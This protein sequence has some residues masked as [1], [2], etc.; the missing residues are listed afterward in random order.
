MDTIACT[1]ILSFSGAAY[2]QE[3]KSL[4]LFC[5][6][7]CVRDINSSLV[8]FP[9]ASTVVLAICSPKLGRGL[10]ILTSLAACEHSLLPFLF[11]CTQKSSAGFISQ[12]PP[13]HLLQ[14]K[15]QQ[16]CQHIPA[17]PTRIDRDG[18]KGHKVHSGN[19]GC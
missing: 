19:A 16:N 4:T 7:G 2:A 18:K 12:L 8:S 5:A 15:L 1:V 11:C 9:R 6:T 17:M 3:Q 10:E 13:F 14:L